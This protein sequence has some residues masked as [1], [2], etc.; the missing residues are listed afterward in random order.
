MIEMLNPFLFI[1]CWVEIAHFFIFKPIFRIELK[2]GFRVSLLNPG[3]GFQVWVLQSLVLFSKMPENLGFFGY[4]FS[5]F[6][7]VRKGVD[8]KVMGERGVSKK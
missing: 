5:Q 4:F 6:F 1:I 3:L 2:P 7:W 8:Q